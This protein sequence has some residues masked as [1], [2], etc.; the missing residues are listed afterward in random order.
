MS[1]ITGSGPQGRTRVLIWPF[2]GGY[3]IIDPRS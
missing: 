3:W 1:G 2:R